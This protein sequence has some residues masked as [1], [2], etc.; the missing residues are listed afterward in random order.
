LKHSIGNQQRDL[1]TNKL[2]ASKRDHGAKGQ[3]GKSRTRGQ[4]KGDLPVFIDTVE[5]SPITGLNEAGPIEGMTTI[6][7]QSLLTPLNAQ[8]TLLA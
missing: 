6:F 3:I 1:S 5:A 8:P 4:P 7:I 2:D